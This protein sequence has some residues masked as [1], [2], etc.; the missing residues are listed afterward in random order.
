MTAPRPLASVLK[1]TPYRGGESA[2]AGQAAARKLSANESPLG[3][4]PKAIEAYRA[5]A[6]KL[7]RYPDGGAGEL[8]Q[9]LARHH[10]LDADRIICGNGSD[11]LISLLV[12]AYC[13]PGD[14][15]LYSQYGFLM[16]P[17]AALA[18]G[19]VPV[20]APE[21]DYIASVDSLLAKVSDRTRLVFLANPNNPTGTYLPDAEIRR[22]RQRLPAGALLAIDAAYA[23]YVVRNDYSAGAELVAARDDVVMTRTFSKIHGLAALR[24][25]WAY[26][27]AEVIDI[28]NRVRGP[29]NVNAVAQAAALAALADVAW[30]DAARTHNDIWLGRT[31]TAIAALGLAIVPS[32]ANFIL[33]RFPAA[34]RH[35]AAAHD[36]LGKRGLI[37]RPMDAYGLPDCL[38]LTIGNEAD[39]TAIVAALQD[40]M[41]AR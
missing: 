25:G 1:I 34:P 8:R 7:H 31:A 11:E 26:A 37:L 29:F 22:L 12:Q 9:A 10:G 13:A 17:L 39:M 33:I 5:M 4:S 40:F 35:A 15:V 6:S 24:V 38:R 2:V 18:H 14:E 16:Y 30:T 23:E 21:R 32:V 3:A 27:G 20:A 19:A 28:L 36:F 41:A